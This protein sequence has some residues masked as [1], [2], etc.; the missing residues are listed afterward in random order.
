MWSSSSSV[1]E[2]SSS[3]ISSSS[4]VESSSSS[5]KVMIAERRYAA[6]AVQFNVVD[7]ILKVNANIDGRKAVN[8]FDVNGTLLMRKTFTGAFY[9][10]HMDALRGKSFVVATLESNGQIVKTK[11]I[12]VK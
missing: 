1:V 3:V 9:E 5:E 11:K 8:L 7:R 10:V 6:S 4:L 2:S 12:R